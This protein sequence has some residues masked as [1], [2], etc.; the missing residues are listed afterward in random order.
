V[1]PE[2][3]N[4]PWCGEPLIEGQFGIY[5]DGGSASGPGWYWNDTIAGEE[6]PCKCGALVGVNTD[7]EYAQTVLVRAVPRVGPAHR[8]GG[9]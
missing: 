4:C 9:R 2:Y 5:D 7:G 3:L 8:G 1:K 6:T